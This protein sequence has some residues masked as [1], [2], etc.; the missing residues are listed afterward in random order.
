MTRLPLIQARMVKLGKFGVF[1]CSE[2]L[3]LHYDI[4]YEIVGLNAEASSSRTRNETDTHEAS[5]ARFGQIRGKKKRKQ[6]GPGRDA[7]R[8][9]DEPASRS[10]LRPL[11]RPPI[12]E[13]VVGESIPAGARLS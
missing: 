10:V 12:I 13:A 4:T 7:D 8:S 6:T 11:K 9:D 5:D 2:L 1:P 3:G